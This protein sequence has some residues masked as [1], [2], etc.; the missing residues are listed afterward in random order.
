V[1]I[2]ELLN[3]FFEEDKTSK[4]SSSSTKLYFFLIYQAN[5][6]FWEGPLILP[7]R[8]LSISLKVDKNTVVKSLK[9]LYKRKLITY[10]PSEYFQK[11]NHTS[12]WFPQ[13]SLK[14]KNNKEV[15]KVANLS[16]IKNNKYTKYF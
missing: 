5:K 14:T 2:Y 11:A 12:I 8:H 3:N 7:I 1:N 6:L 4:L 16:T 10:Y 9:E 15:K 13:P